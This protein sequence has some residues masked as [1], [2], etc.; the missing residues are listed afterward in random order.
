[1]SWKNKILFQVASVYSHH[2]TTVILGCP[3]WYEQYQY[4]WNNIILFIIVIL[5]LFLA[6][7]SASFS[8][9]C[10][11]VCLCPNFSVCSC[12][13]PKCDFNK[14]ALQLYWNR[15]SAW[16]FPSKFA[17]YFQNTFSIEHLWRAAFE[18]NFQL[19]RQFFMGIENESVVICDL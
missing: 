17:A 16:V 19:L 13:Y 1:M 10:F 3:D 2:S 12:P 15:T 11:S 4:L 9:V 18:R 7:F 14:L 6:S 8:R 5:L